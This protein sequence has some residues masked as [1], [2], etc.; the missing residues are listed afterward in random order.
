[1]GL[2]ASAGSSVVA[3]HDVRGGQGSERVARG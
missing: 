3:S 2:K 1:M